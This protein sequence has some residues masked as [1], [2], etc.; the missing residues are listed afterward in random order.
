MAKQHRSFEARSMAWIDSC[1]GET[2]NQEVAES[3]F[4]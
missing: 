2:S 4:A 3:E 1:E